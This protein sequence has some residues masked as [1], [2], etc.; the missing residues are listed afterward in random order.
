MSAAHRPVKAPSGPSPKTKVWDECGGDYGSPACSTRGNITANVKQ[1]W[2]DF[3]PRNMIIAL[4]CRPL[5]QAPILM[6]IHDSDTRPT[7]DGIHTCTHTKRTV[8]YLIYT[9]MFYSFIILSAAKKKKR[10]TRR[11]TLTM[12]VTSPLRSSSLERRGGGA[13]HEEHNQ[14]HLFSKSMLPSKDTHSIDT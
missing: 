2:R 4:N 14:G 3:K 5:Q 1:S 8:E 13:M 11:M 9:L 12:T 10:N 6:C 7:Q